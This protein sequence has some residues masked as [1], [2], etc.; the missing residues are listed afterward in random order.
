[1]LDDTELPDPPDNPEFNKMDPRF[2]RTA[3]LRFQKG[4]TLG[5][6]NDARAAQL[7]REALL[8]ALRR[9]AWARNTQAAM[10]RVARRKR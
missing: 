4:I 10:G 8:D 2:Q 5:F 1:M 7:A 9:A 6:Q 3:D